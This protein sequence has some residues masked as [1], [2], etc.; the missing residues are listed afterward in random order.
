MWPLKEGVTLYP[1][2][3]VGDKVSH[4]VELMAKNNLN[5]I[6]VLKSNHP[7]GMLYLQDALKKLGLYTP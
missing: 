3:T 6:V 5:A 1:S 7:V 2:V 4:A